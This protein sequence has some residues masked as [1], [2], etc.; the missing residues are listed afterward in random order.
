MQDVDWNL[1]LARLAFLDGYFKRM[2]KEVAVK[3]EK[4]SEPRQPQEEARRAQLPP[5]PSQRAAWPAWPV[6]RR[7]WHRRVHRPAKPQAAA[8]GE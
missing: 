2:K 5:A 8:R 4:L 3:N 7:F 6:H 1:A